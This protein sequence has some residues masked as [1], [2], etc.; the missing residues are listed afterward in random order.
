[1]RELGKRRERHLARRATAFPAAPA[2]SVL[3]AA[4]DAGECH[5]LHE[6]LRLVEEAAVF[7]Q[8]KECWATSF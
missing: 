2:P 8:S 4:Q 5:L 7:Q 3:V 6:L 1:M